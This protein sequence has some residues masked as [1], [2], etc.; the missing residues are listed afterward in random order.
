MIS[1]HGNDWAINFHEW[2]A[3]RYDRIDSSNKEVLNLRTLEH[4]DNHARRDHDFDTS[5]HTIPE[6]SGQHLISKDPPIVCP[7]CHMTLP[8]HSSTRSQAI[9]TEASNDSDVLLKVKSRAAKSGA[10]VRFAGDDEGGINE[11]T[12]DEFSQHQTSP[13][14]KHLNINRDLSSHIAEH[15]QRL[16]LLTLRLNVDAASMDSGDEFDS[17]NPAADNGISAHTTST[18]RLLLNETEE[19]IEDEASSKSVIEKVLSNFVLTWRTPA[20][21]I[22][23]MYRMLNCPWRQDCGT[24]P[25]SARMTAHSHS[26]PMMLSK[27]LSHR[28]MSKHTY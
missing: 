15:L 21:L 13:D 11:E 5:T 10:K 9:T 7:L 14:D 1:Q 26:C 22:W 17:D 18:I 19:N 16:A 6:Q 24:P 28:I 27:V 12:E 3:Q 23:Q 8:R 25:L 20:I 4:L 2:P